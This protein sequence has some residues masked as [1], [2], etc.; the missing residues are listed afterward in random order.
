MERTDD[1]SYLCDQGA[2]RYANTYTDRQLG[3]PIV[4]LGPSDMI[5]QTRY[6]LTPSRDD[7]NTYKY[8]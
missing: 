6:D 4:A 7:I 8:I 2:L 5:G 1:L 3:Q